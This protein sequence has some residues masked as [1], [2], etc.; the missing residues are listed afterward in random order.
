MKRNLKLL[1]E[2]I[3]K[4]GYENVNSKLYQKMRHEILNEKN[5]KI[6]YNDILDFINK[7]SK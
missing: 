4:L 6:V 5:K 3:K 2:F 7:R 1:E